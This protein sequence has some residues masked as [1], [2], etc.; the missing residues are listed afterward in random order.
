MNRIK[1]LAAALGTAAV[2]AAAM[3]SPAASAGSN[4]AWSV[5]VGGPGFAV[6]AGEPGWACSQTASTRPAS[7]AA[8]R[9]WPC[10]SSTIGLTRR[11]L[12]SSLSSAEVAR[13]T[14]RLPV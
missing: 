11:G 8:T 1:M 12:K 4:V 3:F 2:G 14:C 10:S 13:Y 5:S 7:V 6:T 9:G